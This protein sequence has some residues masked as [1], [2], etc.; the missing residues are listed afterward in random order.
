MHIISCHFANRWICWK[1][2]IYSTVVIVIF[3]IYGIDIVSLTSRGE[4]GWE[5][6]EED[7]EEALRLSP[8][9]AKAPAEKKIEKNGRLVGG[10]VDGGGTSWIFLVFCCLLFVLVFTLIPSFLED[11]CDLGGISFIFFPVPNSPIWT[12][13]MD[14]PIWEDHPEALYGSAMCLIK[15]EQLPEALKHCEVPK[16]AKS[17]SK[18]EIGEI[19]IF[20]GWSWE[21]EGTP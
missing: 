18:K 16:W 6:A 9:N 1:R 2:H 7:A 4:T 17:R 10:A 3:T 12:L 11:W 20:S 19:E 5:L 13:M 14:A 21:M 8:G 15:L